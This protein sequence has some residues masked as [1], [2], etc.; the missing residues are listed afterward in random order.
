MVLRRLF[1]VLHWI[2]FI[3]FIG[4]WVLAQIW[5]IGG[6]SLNYDDITNR[7][8]DIVDEILF[9]R[10]GFF[11]ALAAWGL[12]IF[13]LIDWITLGKTTLFPWKRSLPKQED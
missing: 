11:P 7:I 3:P 12:P 2:F 10:T 9:L 6:G 8:E 13:V 1:Y 5:V 4:V